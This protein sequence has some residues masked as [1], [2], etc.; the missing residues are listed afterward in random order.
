MRAS[1]TALT[2]A[3][4]FGR[5]ARATLSRLRSAFAE[6][7][8]AVPGNVSKAADLHRAL[9]IDMKLGWKAFKVATSA[10]P[11]AAGP[12]V[13]GPVNMSTFLKAAAKRGVPAKLIDAAAR[14]R[15]FRSPGRHACR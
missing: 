15:G 9:R 6:L 10:D 8:A 1:E 12:H 13:P 14:G 4:L 7:I 2:E 5:E 3:G 11:L